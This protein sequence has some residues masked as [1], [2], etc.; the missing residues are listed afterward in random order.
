[1][2][3]GFGF[4]RVWI[5]HQTSGSGLSGLKLKVRVF[6]F[7]G[8]RPGTTTNVEDTALENLD[9]LNF[10]HMHPDEF[11]IIIWSA[12]V[13]ALVHILFE[14]MFSTKREQSF[15]GLFIL[16]PYEE[17]CDADDDDVQD[18]CLDYFSHCINNEKSQA[19]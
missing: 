16:V 15:F 11:V 1:M 4:D 19:N 18:N 17:E 5:F 8:T 14:M 2:N 7:S 13:V 6:G 10:V 12:V 9:Q 3:F